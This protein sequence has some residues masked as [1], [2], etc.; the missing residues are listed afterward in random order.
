MLATCS[1]SSKSYF[2]TSSTLQYAV[3]AKMIVTNPKANYDISNEPEEV[4]AET[5][6]K[7]PGF[8]YLPRFVRSAHDHRDALSART[9]SR[10]GTS[11]LMHSARV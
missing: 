4:E 7:K 2:E 8:D 5:P 9:D 3:R 10:L 11:T 1:P 6:K